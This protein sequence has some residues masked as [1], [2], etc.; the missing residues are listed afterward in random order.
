MKR[1]NVILISIMVISLLLVTVL[2][3]VVA[4]KFNNSDFQY[5]DRNLNIERI[6]LPVFK[7]VSLKTINGLKIFTSDSSNLEIQ[8][9][10]KDM[11]FLSNSGDTLF[12]KS[13]PGSTEAGKNEMQLAL[14]LPSNTRIHIDSC[15]H[16]ELKGD[17]DAT[18]PS[19]FFISLSASD[20]SI[21]ANNY[22]EFFK[23]L[24][25]NDLGF[26]S[27][28]FGE[29]VFAENVTLINVHKARLTNG[30]HIQNL[31]TSATV[32]ARIN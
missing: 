3:L 4:G 18:H 10:K 2:T 32:M 16:V 27:V 11:L 30:Y 13:I 14:Y 15:R 17:Y 23:D 26:S 25:I 12:L 31:V 22:R 19:S 8:N 9:E 21:A 6:K 5:V 20:L 1:S 24:T 28:E 7:V 29:S